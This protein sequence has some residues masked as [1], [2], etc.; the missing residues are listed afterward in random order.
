MN[1]ADLLSR[2][3]DAHGQRIAAELGDHSLTYAELDTLAGR[4][5]VLLAARGVS[6]GDREPKGATGK[7]LKREIVASRLTE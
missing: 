3:A 2:S 7:I 5:A 4:V 1:L 6:P